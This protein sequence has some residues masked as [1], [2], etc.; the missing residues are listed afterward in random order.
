LTDTKEEV[1]DDTPNPL[2]RGSNFVSY[3]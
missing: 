1:P 2:S 3:E